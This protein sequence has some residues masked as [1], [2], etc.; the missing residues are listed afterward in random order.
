MGYTQN[1]LGGLGTTRQMVI[2]L[3]IVAD[4]TV[5][6][7]THLYFTLAGSGTTFVG[8]AYS[9]TVSLGPATL[10]VCVAIAC[11]IKRT[12]TTSCH[13]NIHDDLEL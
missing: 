8:S 6:I 4:I 12:P 11:S 7:C 3:G 5:L 1:S 2:C 9:V 10:G 13:M